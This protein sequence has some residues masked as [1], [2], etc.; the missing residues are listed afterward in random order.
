MAFKSLKQWEVIQ[1]FDCSSTWVPAQVIAT[2]EMCGQMHYR[3]HYIRWGLN[4]DI[5]VPT[6]DLATRVR[7]MAFWPGHN[8]DPN[9][10]NVNVFSPWTRQWHNLP[11]EERKTFQHLT[12]IRVQHKPYGH[13]WMRLN[14]PFVMAEWDPR[15][16][17]M[18]ANPCPDAAC[19][20]EV[21]PFGCIL[22][23][24]WIS[25]LVTHC[26]S[27]IRDST[28]CRIHGLSTFLRNF[29]SKSVRKSTY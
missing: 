5:W 24:C 20:P 4:W 6:S 16:G 28:E 15:R 25:M 13:C 10:A 29:P 1:H 12:V 9:V 18:C 3:I 23:R 7:S 11:V 19:K 8:S 27:T 2:E 21:L 26:L 17:H 14:S 22:F